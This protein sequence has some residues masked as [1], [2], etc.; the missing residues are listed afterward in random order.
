MLF[1]GRMESERE[2]E[3]EARFICLIFCLNSLSNFKLSR[4]N[5][6]QEFFIL[7]CLTNSNSM[8]CPCQ[9]CQNTSCMKSRKRKTAHEMLVYT[10]Y[11]L[12]AWYKYSLAKS[13]STHGNMSLVDHVLCSFFAENER[14]VLWSFHGSEYIKI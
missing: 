6:K 12:V 3:Q 5:K 10:K 9:T 13:T 8:V 11:L 14:C 2:F 4:S 1:E 7:D